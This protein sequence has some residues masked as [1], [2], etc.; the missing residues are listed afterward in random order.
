M[1]LPLYIAKRI[2]S[3]NNAQQKVSK[4]AIHIATAGVA[5]GLAVMIISVCIVLGLSILYVIK[6]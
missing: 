2:Y 6:L 5:V 3:D 4:P 1:N